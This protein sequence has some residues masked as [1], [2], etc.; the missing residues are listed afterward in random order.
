MTGITRISKMLRAVPDEA[1]PSIDAEAWLKT[2]QVS[3][4][5]LTLEAVTEQ[6]EARRKAVKR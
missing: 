4:P 3:H 1:V 6:I 2:F 5:D